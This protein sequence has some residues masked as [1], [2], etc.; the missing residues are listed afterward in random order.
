MPCLLGCIFL[1]RTSPVNVIPLG[2]TKSV[3][4]WYVIYPYWCNHCAN[5]E[6]W[7]VA[8]FSL[9]IGIH[10][11]EGPCAAAAPTARSHGGANSRTNSMEVCCHV[12]WGLVA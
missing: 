12:A 3:I 9:I 4:P 11:P 10:V 7:I 2:Q 1:P 6:V 5:V 8:G